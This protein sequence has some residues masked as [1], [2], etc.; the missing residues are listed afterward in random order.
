MASLVIS[1]CLVAVQD[2]E[3]VLGSLSRGLDWSRAAGESKEAALQRLGP[4]ARM[5]GVTEPLTVRFKVLEVRL[6]FGLHNGRT[7][8]GDEFPTRVLA[9][10]ERGGPISESNGNQAPVTEFIPSDLKRSSQGRRGSGSGSQSQSVE[11]PH[12]VAG[13]K[14]CALVVLLEAVVRPDQ[15]GA[16][17]PL[18]HDAETRK[19]FEA[20]PPAASAGASAGT[21]GTLSE[22]T[23]GKREA[24]VDAH[25]RMATVVLGS[26]AYVPYPEGGKLRLRGTAD[27]RTLTPK[28]FKANHFELPLA[29]DQFTRCVASLLSEQAAGNTA[30]TLLVWP[31]PGSCDEMLDGV[32]WQ[33]PDKPLRLVKFT[34]EATAPPEKE[35]R[36]RK[37]K[38]S[39]RSVGRS[40]LGEADGKESRLLLDETPRDPADDA[41]APGHGDGENGDDRSSSDGSSGGSSDG[42][43]K[44][45]SGGGA[46][47]G[48]AR[49]SWKLWT[50]RAPLKA[51]G[52][53]LSWTSPPPEFS[54]LSSLGKE[55]ARLL[56]GRLRRGGRRGE[57]RP[58]AARRRRTRGI[59]GRRPRL[60]RF[61]IGPARALCWARY[62]TRSL[63]TRPK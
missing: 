7:W 55:R 62:S 11:L 53:P 4:A 2:W 56:P 15:S 16:R 45:S 35:R 26:A 57:G 40:G 25:S 19:L 54:V 43:S 3:A 6:R 12:L 18:P 23:S 29:V 10:E 5:T 47:A 34:C 20:A 52:R 36:G 17:L 30:G 50:A 39:G 31:S 13:S 49:T 58:A 24:W 32:R 48:G 9:L 37:G 1:K 44:G 60:G 41:R 28:E 46:R 38:K 51:C 59:P 42:S 8:L 63:T 61:R 21:T 33:D 14:H 27:A 22:E